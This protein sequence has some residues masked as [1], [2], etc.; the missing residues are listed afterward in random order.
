MASYSDFFTQTA[1]WGAPKNT[2]RVPDIAKAT[3]DRTAYAAYRISGDNVPV[4]NLPQSQM[5]ETMHYRQ[6]ASPLNSL[7]FSVDNTNTLQT[8][9]RDTVLAKSGGKYAI[10]RQ[11]DDDLFLIMRSYYLQ[12]SR[13]DP[14]RVAEELEDL[15]TR[16]VNFSSDKIMVNVEAYKTY[17]A[18]QENFP[19][20]IAAPIN[21]GVY[22]TRTG[23]LKSFF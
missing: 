4:R 5:S 8:R 10:D 11:N 3:G 7:F 12:Y 20:P 19:M 17:R 9:I 15:N 14:A 21:P 2:G 6:S 22:G 18:D 1:I 13:N 16:V 23:E